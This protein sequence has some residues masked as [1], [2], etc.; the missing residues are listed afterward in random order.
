LFTPSRCP[1]RWTVAAMANSSQ[2]KLL[3]LQ[4]M[5]DISK[6]SHTT[7]FSA[8]FRDD[9]NPYTWDVTIFGPEGTPYEAGMFKAELVFPTDYPN[10][11]PKM[12]FLSEMHHPN[13]YAADGRV[14]ISILH[15]PGEDNFGYE[16]AEERWRPIHTAES[17]LVSVISMI[18]DPNVDS[19][20][21]IDAAKMFREDRDNWKKQVKRCVRKSQDDFC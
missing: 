20:A 4:Q 5:K 10:Q 6:T 9:D 16:A 18:A 13:V 8:G 17:I 12:R 14:C 15:A 3:L 1:R 7:M 11:P 21:N 19:P 2:S